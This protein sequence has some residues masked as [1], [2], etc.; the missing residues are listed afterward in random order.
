[1]N[2]WRNL[3][4]KALLS[5]HKFYLTVKAEPWGYKKFPNVGE[6]VAVLEEII[7]LRIPVS[8]LWEIE[9]LLLDNN[10]STHG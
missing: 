3:S 2:N 5:L 10:I 6:K 1:M 7:W 4:D 8:H 9:K